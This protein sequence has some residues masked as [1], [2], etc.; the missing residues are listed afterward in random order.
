[1][2][3]KTFHIVSIVLLVI[4]L[5]FLVACVIRQEHNITANAHES[6]SNN[7]K[8]TEHSN[9]AIKGHDYLDSSSMCEKACDQLIDCKAYVWKEDIKHCALKREGSRNVRHNEQGATTYVRN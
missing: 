1:M 2:Q 8:Y 4:I 3:T 5:I 7:T 9:Q 6:F